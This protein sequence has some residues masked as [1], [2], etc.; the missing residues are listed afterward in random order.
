MTMLPLLDATFSISK[1]IESIWWQNEN[2]NELW[3]QEKSFHRNTNKTSSLEGLN[4]SHFLRPNQIIYPHLGDMVKTKK[5]FFEHFNSCTENISLFL[6]DRGQSKTKN[7]RKPFRKVL[8]CF[9]LVGLSPKSLTWS[10]IWT[11]DKFRLQCQF[12]YPS[13]YSLLYLIQKTKLWYV[14][15]IL[16]LM[17]HTTTC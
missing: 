1:Q 14:F 15:H 3:C 4:L 5:P 9:W 13:S 17:S 16:W 12:R 11:H 7:Q 6:L 2:M 10:E 8:R